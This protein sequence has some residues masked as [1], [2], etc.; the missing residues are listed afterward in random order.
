M[1]MMMMMMMMVIVRNTKNNNTIIKFIRSSAF[2]KYGII[3]YYLSYFKLPGDK[4]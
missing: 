1:M 4:Y 3:V 2:T